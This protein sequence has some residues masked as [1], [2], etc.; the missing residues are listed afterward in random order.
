MQKRSVFNLFP[1]S[2]IIPDFYLCLSLI[3]LLLAPAQIQLYVF[4]GPCVDQFDQDTCKQDMHILF[5]SVD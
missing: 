2:M 1:L 4:I 3:L 5:N